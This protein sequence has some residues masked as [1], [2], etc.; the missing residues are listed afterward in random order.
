MNFSKN[1]TLPAGWSADS[2]A[3][4]I[5]DI[6]IFSCISYST[7]RLMHHYF[8]VEDFVLVTTKGMFQ[9]KRRLNIILLS[10]P[11]IIKKE[12]DL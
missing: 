8:A 10:L 6:Y 4:K 11:G 9:Y 2:K 1:T 12:I 5:S 3:L 7:Y